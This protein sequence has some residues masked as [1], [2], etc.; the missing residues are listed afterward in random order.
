MTKPILILLR[1]SDS[2]Q[3]NVYNLC[4]MILMVDYRISMYM[5]E[6]NYGDYFPSVI[7]SEDVKYEEVSDDDDPPEYFSDDE[8]VSAT[9][10]GIPSRDNNRL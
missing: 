6:I 1:I 5:P 9:E 3:P 8:Y 10:D 7:E 2:N 4:F